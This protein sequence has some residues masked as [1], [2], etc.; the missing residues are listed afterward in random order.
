MFF[1]QIFLSCRDIL[2]KYLLDY[3]FLNLYKIKNKIKIKIKIN[4]LKLN[5]LIL[6]NYL[7]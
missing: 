2:E 4:N 1:G 6:I 5:K 3:D 7:C